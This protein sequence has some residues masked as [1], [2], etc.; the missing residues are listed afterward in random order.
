MPLLMP[1]MTLVV[2]LLEV[3]V[4]L[5]ETL[6]VPR[7]KTIQRHSVVATLP[8]RLEPEHHLHL[9]VVHRLTHSAG[10]TLIR[11]AE[12]IRLATIQVVDLE[13]LEVHSRKYRRRWKTSS[14]T[15]ALLSLR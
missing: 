4:S 15:M 7:F 9:K 12:A 13:V 14:Q 8:I 2:I 10:E 3:P 6:L 5:V 1:S 11:S